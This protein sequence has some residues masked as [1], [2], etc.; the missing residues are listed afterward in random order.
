MKKENKHTF[1]IT[2]LLCI[3]SVIFTLLTKLADVQPIG[4]QKSEIG[5]AA[6]NGFIHNLFGVN[7]IWYHITDWLGLIPVFTT[8]VFFA[9]GVAQLIRRKSLFKVDKSII[10]LGIFY[11]LVIAVYLF[12]ESYIINYRPVLMNGR[13]EAS[14]PSSHTLMTICLMSVCIDQCSRLIRSKKINTAV[15]IISY[16]IIAVTIIGRLISGVHWFTDII[17]GILISLTLVSLYHSAI[18][19]LLPQLNLNSKYST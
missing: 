14:Y 17:G 6:V 9:V 15:K 12:F 19:V 2:V 7:M 1:F 5:F 13:L 16:A 8:F 11:I 18:K 3:S 10:I 4:P